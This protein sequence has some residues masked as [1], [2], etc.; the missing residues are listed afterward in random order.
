MAGVEHGVVGHP[1]QAGG[2]RLV[3]RL[4]IAAGE[5]GPAAS[6]EEQGVP[7]D[8]PAVD[9]EALAARRVARGVDAG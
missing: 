9:Q 7:G 3:E 1:G 2:E 4:G 5:V 6:V 8:E